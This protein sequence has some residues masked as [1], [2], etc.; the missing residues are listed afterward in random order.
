MLIF[1]TEIQAQQAI[2]QNNK[3]KID[4]GIR[5]EHIH[6]QHTSLTIGKQEYYYRQYHPGN[7]SVL[8]ILKYDQEQQYQQ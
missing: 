1:N 6:T 3:T 8:D 2:L 5:Q 4:T 7:G